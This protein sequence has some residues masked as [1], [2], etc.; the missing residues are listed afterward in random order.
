[1]ADLF[2]AESLEPQAA[3][4][5]YEEITS[6]EVD[7]VI[8]DRQ[9]HHLAELEIP[10]LVDPDQQDGEIRRMALEHQPHMRFD[11][12]DLGAARID[13]VNMVSRCVMR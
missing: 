8:A 1:M 6:E 12:A 11:A 9:L 7:R 3:G 5:D 13:R 10:A 4:G 2:D